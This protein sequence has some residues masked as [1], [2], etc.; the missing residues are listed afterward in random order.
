[1]GS[2]LEEKFYFH[3]PGMLSVNDES[4]LDGEKAAK[5]PAF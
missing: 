2:E 1:M 3:L 5:P 4:P